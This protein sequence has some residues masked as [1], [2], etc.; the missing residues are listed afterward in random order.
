V[1]GRTKTPR[2]HV[3]NRTEIRAPLHGISGLFVRNRTR[4]DRVSTCGQ[5][6][7]WGQQLYS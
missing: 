6:F 7:S 2:E 4:I 1:R 5:L 3:R